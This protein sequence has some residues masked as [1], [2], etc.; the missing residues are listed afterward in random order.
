MIRFMYKDEIDETFCLLNYF[1]NISKTSFFKNPYTKIIVSST[2]IINGVLVFDYIYDRIEIN[3]IIVAKKYR[4]CHIAS[5]MISFL[6]AFAKAKK[7]NNITLEVNKNNKKAIALYKKYKFKG[8]GI[9][10]NYYGSNDA[11]LMLREIDSYE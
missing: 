7:V 6:I 1:K 2:D 4:N 3:Y 11:L 5:Q 8:V 10:K 9:R